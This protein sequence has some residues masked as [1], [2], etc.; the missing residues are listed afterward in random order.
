MYSSTNSVCR[1][2]YSLC[3]RVYEICCP[4]KIQSV[5]TLRSDWVVLLDI[6]VSMARLMHTSS[7]PVSTWISGVKGRV[8]THMFQLATRLT[9]HSFCPCS[10]Q[11]G[12]NSQVIYCRKERCQTF[13]QIRSVLIF[14]DAFINLWLYELQ[15]KGL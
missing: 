10:S 9:V 1:M 8:A 6:R 12:I 3:S 5:Y 11:C 14:Q 13:G 4:N 7:N 2:I 15:L